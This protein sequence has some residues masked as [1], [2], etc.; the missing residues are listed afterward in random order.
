M[1]LAAAHL[2]LQKRLVVE[3]LEEKRVSRLGGIHALQKF[4]RPPIERARDDVL[5]VI[6]EHVGERRQIPNCGGEPKAF[7]RFRHFNLVSNRTV[8]WSRF[9]KDS[10]GCELCSL[11]KCTVTQSRTKCNP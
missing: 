8:G 1:V 4:D 3:D 9:E 2:P 10:C 5:P 11:R 6:P 7:D